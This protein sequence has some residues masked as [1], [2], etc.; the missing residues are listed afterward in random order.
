MVASP[1]GETRVVVA[2]AFRVCSG[3]FFSVQK[4]QLRSRKRH[5]TPTCGSA[6]RIVCAHPPLQKCS[7][8]H[9]TDTHPT[10]LRTDKFVRGR[11]ANSLPQQSSSASMA[12]SVD[13]QRMYGC[14][15]RFGNNRRYGQKQ[16]LS[17]NT[18]CFLATQGPLIGRYTH[19]KSMASPDIGV[20]HE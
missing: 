1:E 11:R 4:V 3:T 9:S 7:L 13:H 17:A 19:R 2:L 20:A 5:E 10:R 8:A 6:R 18:S 15:H 16:F 14:S 12:E